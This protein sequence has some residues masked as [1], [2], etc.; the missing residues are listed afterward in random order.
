MCVCVSMS[1][2]SAWYLCVASSV[3]CNPGGGGG[4][5][6]Q[7]PDLYGPGV[8]RVSVMQ[9]ALLGKDTV[10]GVAEFTIAELVGWQAESVDSVVAAAVVRA[11]SAVGMRP[12]QYAAAAGGLVDAIEEDVAAQRAAEILAHAHL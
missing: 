5:G 4:G 3:C 10:I 11:A 6:A 2:V 1:I 12:E 9:S 7:T 8:V